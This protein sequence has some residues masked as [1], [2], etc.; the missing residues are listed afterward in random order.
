M[1]RRLSLLLSLLLG[2]SSAVSALDVSYYTTSSR[3][4]GETWVKIRTDKEA[5]YQLT[6][7]QLRGLGFQDPTKVQVYG[8]GALALADGQFSTDIPDDIVPVATR[9]TA[10]G[11]ILFFGEGDVRLTANR[12]IQSMGFFDYKRSYGD[13]A[14]YYFLSDAEGTVPVPVRDAGVADERYSPNLSH[15]HIDLQEED[16]QSPSEG[17]TSFLGKS[18]SPG[19]SPSFTFRIKNFKPVDGNDKLSCGTFSYVFGLYSNKALSLSASLPDNVAPFD[20]SGTLDSTLL[21]MQSGS[22][23]AYA[24][25]T[26]FRP[27]TASGTDDLSDSEVTFKVNVPA[28]SEISFCAVDRVFLTYPRAN[29]LDAENPYLVMNLMENLNF[30]G[31]RMAFPETAENEIEMWNI[32]DLFNITSYPATYDSETRT[33]VF[34]YDKKAYRTVA[35]NPGYTFP[36]PEIVGTVAGQ[37]LHGCPAPDMLIVTTAE[38]M[39]YAERLANL[40]RSYQGMDVLVVDHRDIY[41]EFSSGARS[42]MAYRRLAKMFYDRDSSKF[43]Y[44]LF[45]GPASYD[46]RCVI[47]PKADRLVCHGQ[48]DPRLTRSAILNYPIDAFFAMMND[49]LTTDNSI[50]QEPVQIA[51]G[52]VS[53]LNQAQADTYVKKVERRFTVPVSAE[54]YN[55]ALLIGGTGDNN[56]HMKHQKQVLD[57]I[58]EYYNPDMNFTYLPIDIYADGVEVPSRKITEALKQGVGYM[59]YSGHGGPT[60]INLWSVANV[61]ATHYDKLPFVMF[62]SCDQFAFDR[63]HGG[64]TE[65]MLFEP[66]GGAIAGF[67]AARSVY[68]SYNQLSCVPM[69]IAYASAKPGA[70]FGDLYVE[71]RNSVLTAF[72]KGE[73]SSTSPSMAFHN[74]LAYNL[75]GDP[76]I[77]VGVPE[78]K[79][80]MTK[81]GSAS[82]LPGMSVSVKPLVPTVFEG[83]V[84]GA[85]GVIDT[86]FNGTAK[87]TVFDG[88]R[89]Y[90]HIVQIDK[91]KDDV[92]N[93]VIDYDVLAFAETKVVDGKFSVEMTLPLSSY[94]EGDNR[95]TVTAQSDG[96]VKAVSTLAGIHVVDY[97]EN[98]AGSDFGA[99]SIK[100]IYVTDADMNPTSEIGA[101]AYLCAVIDPSSAGLNF[102]EG[103]VS[104]TPKVVLDGLSPTNV[105]S[106]CFISQENG[107]MIMKYPLLGLAEGAHTIELTV[108]NNA[109]LFDCA[110]ID[111]NVVTHLLSP[112]LVID[113]PF[114]SAEA[115]IGLDGI[116]SASYTKLAIIN[117]VGE[118]VFT[119]ENPV[120]P[121]KWNLKDSNG[122]D[123]PD[124]TYNATV[125]VRDGH[126]YG[127]GLPVKI[128]VLR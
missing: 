2:L 116:A 33:N 37:N 72:D 29:L 41:N 95:L 58:R 67:A 69:A 92:L 38:M 25:A 97:D 63:M 88:A 21:A 54:I 120:F 43:K 77:P 32:D 114:A 91:D 79:V 28:M 51:V 46:N 80:K 111:F 26:G 17:G 78:R 84:L 18:Y 35:F 27:F 125:F 55:H 104:T 16:V 119:T 110:K 83:A 94:P 73:L 45:F 128:V 103:A 122:N 57:T 74:M 106:R 87:V 113:E 39:P 47:V 6:Y 24:E 90:Q 107:E 20:Y 61:N 81:I 121:Y 34:V 99:P 1:I 86:G 48:P 56:T 66:K 9:H 19:D 123:V 4:S 127:Y 93:A 15:I 59:T 100:Q 68:I 12:I 70:V 14:S 126:Y 101:T 98:A 112:E 65:S 117:N 118:T 75:A 64:L 82:V 7:D 85:D 49:V 62:S 105:M 42:S 52:R 31:R 50:D 115:V 22:T 13:T 109:G 71:A 96:G 124:G 44:L 8:Y 3:L 36:S 11:R 30:S 89:T 10:D 108:T 102:R 23:D 53:A 5:I 60:S 76:A 40:H